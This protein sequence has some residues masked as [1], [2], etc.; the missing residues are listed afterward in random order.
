MIDL[1]TLESLRERLEKATG[2]DR[3]ISVD[4][5]LTFIRPD[6]QKGEPRRYEYHDAPN[7]TGS[8]DAAVA[9]VE[10]VFGKGV[11]LSMTNLYGVAHAELP[12]NEPDVTGSVGRFNCG[13][14]PLAICLALVEALIAKEQQ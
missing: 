9:L 8:I 5:W 12:L 13:S 6:L 1:A 10:R 7:I 2:P 3:W 4:L 14:F 11:E